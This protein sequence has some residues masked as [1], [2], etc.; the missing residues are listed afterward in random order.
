MS[1]NGTAFTRGFWCESGD[2]QPGS[3]HRQPGWHSN[4]RL[5]NFWM[6]QDV[7]YDNTVD[8]TGTGDRSEYDTESYWKVVVVFYERYWYRGSSEP[9]SVNIINLT[10]LWSRVIQ[11]HCRFGSLWQR[12]NVKYSSWK[13]PPSA[14]TPTTLALLV[15]PRVL[16][17]H[18]ARD[19]TY[20]GVNNTALL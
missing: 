9:S 12:S 18:V 3:Q 10:W 8:L 1:L 11:F 17:K 6:F 20:T 14:Y 15:T 13:P 5:D 7:K 19:A 2:C 4:T 16:S